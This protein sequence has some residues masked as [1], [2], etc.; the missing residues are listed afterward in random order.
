MY[1]DKALTDIKAVQTLSRLNRALP[2][3]LDTLILDFAND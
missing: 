2:G 1:V 3:K